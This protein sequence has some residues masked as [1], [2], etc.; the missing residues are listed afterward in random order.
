MLALYI[1]LQTPH[2]NSQWMG[3][4]VTHDFLMISIFHEDT[5]VIEILFI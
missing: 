3:C 2:C 1:Y 5:L 4:N